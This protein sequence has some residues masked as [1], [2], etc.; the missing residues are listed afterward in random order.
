MTSAELEPEFRDAPAAVR[1]LVSVGFELADDFL[2]GKFEVQEFRNLMR[3]LA[4]LHYRNSMLR[5]I[6]RFVRHPIACVVSGCPR[7]MLEQRDVAILT[8]VVDTSLDTAFARDCFWRTAYHANPT[9]KRKRAWEQ[10]PE[11]RRLE[12]FPLRLRGSRF[13]GCGNRCAEGVMYCATHIRFVNHRRLQLRAWGLPPELADL[14]MS[15]L[16]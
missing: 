10:P 1:A 7:Y 5:A 12:T 4:A 13:R 8:R 6:R 16:L 3:K 14:A 15:F 11:R 9:R 2:E